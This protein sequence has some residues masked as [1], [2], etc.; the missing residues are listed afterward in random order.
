VITFSLSSFKASPLGAATYLTLSLGALLRFTLEKKGSPFVLA[1]GCAP[2]SQS[3]RFAR[4][5]DSPHP[6][7][8]HERK[9]N[10]SFLPRDP[11]PP[12]AGRR[13]HQLIFAPPL[14]EDPFPPRL[15]FST[16]ADELFLFFYRDPRL[17][18]SPAI[19]SF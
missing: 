19:P 2:S 13:P 18:L 6:N 12:W 8:I 14:S 1:F 11:P 10:A 17:L 15:L 5:Q 16:M 7:A 3:R 9:I 4:P